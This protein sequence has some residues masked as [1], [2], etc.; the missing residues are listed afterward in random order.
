V[1]GAA[2]SAGAIAS[3][4]SYPA[5]LAVGIGPLAANVTNAVAG[6]TIGIG[7]TLSSREELRNQWW[8][9]RKW[10]PL[11]VAG[12]AA[13]AALLLLTP[14]RVFDWLV[15]F[16]VAGAALVL[17]AQRRLTDWH[18][19]RP[20]R[21]AEPAALVALGVVGIYS[22]YFGAGSGIMIL[23]VLLVLVE[24]DLARANALKNT[25][26]TVTDAV[27]AVIFALAGRVVWLAAVPL[28]V[29]VFAGGLVGPAIA[30]RAAPAIL[31]GA[32]AAC[33]FG[34]A[35]WLLIRAAR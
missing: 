25:L 15:P 10:A 14:S 9:L 18:Q 34:L 16:L 23:A 11:C 30:R 28:A 33:G 3:L 29:G 35:V 4:V 2:G 6:V 13:G 5:L 17:L 12:G 32:I 7:S 8:R 24:P 22:G 26:L 1:A 19:A 27:P 21:R 20:R 31:R